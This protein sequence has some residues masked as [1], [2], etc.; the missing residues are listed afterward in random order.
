[1]E[2]IKWISSELKVDERI[3]EASLN[4]LD[5]GCTPHFIVRYRREQVGSL[6]AEGLFRIEQSVR[7]LPHECT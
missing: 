3:V 1:M 5:D 4:L 7:N 2:R 6:D